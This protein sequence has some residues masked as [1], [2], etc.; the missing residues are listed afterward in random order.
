MLRQAIA[1]T[2]VLCFVCATV[3]AQTGD[4]SLRD[5]AVTHAPAQEAEAAL[6]AMLAQLNVPGR[7]MA[8]PERNRLMVQGGDNIHRFVEQYLLSQSAV[9]TNQRE[10]HAAPAQQPSLPRAV[11]YPTVPQQ[12]SHQRQPTL[13]PSQSQSHSGETSGLLTKTYDV[14]PEALEATVQHL[15]RHYAQAPSVRLASIAETATLIVVAPADMHGDIAGQIAQALTQPEE[16]RIVSQGLEPRQP[17]INTQ[18]TQWDLRAPDQTPRYQQYAKEAQQFENNVKP[19]GVQPVPAGPR[20][21]QSHQYVPRDGQVMQATLGHLGI[22]TDQ[23]LGL[24]LKTP[25]P[26]IIG[27][28]RQ[29]LGDQISQHPFEGDPAGA[30][31]TIYLSEEYGSI[32]L[33]W[34]TRSN[35]VVVRGYPQMQERMARLLTTLDSQQALENGEIRFTSLRNANPKT[36]MQLV[37]AVQREQSGAR[38]TA[39]SNYMVGNLFY[40]R[41]PQGQPQPGSPQ[42]QD[43]QVGQPNGQSL[44]QPAP[45]AGAN[46][47]RPVRAEV[48]EGIG[49]VLTGTE[50][51]LEQLMALIDQ[52]VAESELSEPLVESYLLRHVDSSS[53]ADVVQDIYDTTYAVRRGPVTITP[54]VN[55][56]SL[57]IIG[58]EGAVDQAKE[59]IRRLDQRG[60]PGAQFRVFKLKNAN[61][62]NVQAAITQLYPTGQN[63]AT[64][65]PQVVVIADDRSNTLVVRASQRDLLEV[66]QLILELDVPEGEFDLELRIFPLRNSQALDLIEVLQQVIVGDADVGFGSGGQTPASIVIKQFDAQNRIV[67]EIRSGILSDVR[68]TADPRANTLVVAAPAGAM[69]LIAQLIFELDA[70]SGVVADIKV[71]PVINGDASALVEMLRTLFGQQA[72]QGGGF[73]GQTVIASATAGIVPLRLS[74]DVRTNSIVAAGSPGDLQIVEAILANLDLDDIADRRTDVVR[75]KNVPAIDI[76]NAITSILQTEADLLGDQVAFQALQQQVIVVPEAI[77]NTL[78]VTSTDRYRDQILQIVETLD[79]E[80]PMVM[81]QVLIAE[82]ALNNTDEFGVELG[83]QDSLLFDRSLLGDLVTTTNTIQTNNGGAVIT[84]TQQI[85]QGASNTPGFAFGN[86]TTPLPNS[87]SD[88]ALSTAGNVGTQGLTSF[89]VGRINNELGYGGLVLSA[90]SESVSV[91]VRALQESRRLDVISR[92]QIQTLDNQPAFVQVGQRVQLPTGST[93]DPQTGVTTVQVGAAENVG[94][95]LGVTPRISIGDLTTPADDQ[96][97]MQIDVEKSEVGPESEGTPLSINAQGDVLRSPRINTVTAQTTLSGVD[98]QTIVLGGLITKSETKVHRR[99]PVLAS[100]PVLGHLFRYD[101]KSVRK[102][103]LMII[104]TPR[105]VR[106]E[107]ETEYL[108]RMETARMS[109]VLSDVTKIHGGDGLYSRYEPW[110]DP[111]C[112]VY[113]DLNPDGF[114]SPVEGTQG[115][116]VPMN[117]PDGQPLQHPPGGEQAPGPPQ[118]GFLNFQGVDSGI[119]QTSYY[120]GGLNPPWRGGY[121]QQQPPMQGIQPGRQDIQRSPNRYAPVQFDRRDDPRSTRPMKLG[122]RPGAR[123]DVQRTPNGYI[124]VQFDPHSY[125]RYAPTPYWRT[126]ALRVNR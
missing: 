69:D 37:R 61:A 13:A 46:P 122:V 7:V 5:Y 52:I 125:P 33:D 43:G 88:L 92:P 118:D 75:L 100:V 97:V 9:G 67:D 58:Q 76:S 21:N 51:D 117:R 38:P 10:Q 87:G 40:R 95:I 115:T 35:K 108:K 20:I 27:A 79:R 15:K 44:F 24:E 57:L 39:N 1:A 110:G 41:Q 30:I 71:F 11:N 22:Q 81:I 53:L 89:S 3:K 90:S 17:E 116:P 85:I 42:N 64:L 91:L 34:N 66:E 2:I 94:I 73:G 70:E 29:G 101:L 114:L 102:T 48:I 119:Q 50:Q 80:P 123:Q 113:P 16:Y 103:E 49:I 62:V 23:G 106:S 47:Q 31:F 74:V 45:L 12:S 107:E 98:G 32:R 78:I 63:P 96:I 18:Q 59:L 84:D 86:P 111:S 25:A 68:I 54:F 105:I 28:L 121:D 99:V 36:V 26:V 19:N 4:E 56:N 55:P 112:V 65:E 104:L 120:Q 77:T 126:G 124:P 60:S 8:D 83:L 93:L 14:A 82:V 72:T 109:W 6:Q